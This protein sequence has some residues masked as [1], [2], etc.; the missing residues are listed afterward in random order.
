[1]LPPLP[2]EFRQ[3]SAKLGSDPQLV[4]G[5]GG[6]TSIKFDNVMW[7]KASGT[8][9]KNALNAD[10]FCPVDV[11][12]AR[13]CIDIDDDNATKEAVLPGGPDLKPSIETTFH[14]LLSDPV[15]LHVHSINVITHAISEEGMSALA[16]KL[17]DI[18]WLD[19]PYCRPGLPLTREIRRRKQAHHNVFILRN[20]GV[21]VSGQTT[22]EAYALLS[23]V[24]KRLTLPSLA[25]PSSAPQTDSAYAESQ[26]QWAPEFSA[27]ATNARLQHI[28]RQFT[29]YPDHCIFLGQALPCIKKGEPLPSQSPPVCLIEDTGVLINQNA[30]PSAIAMLGCL[31]DVLLKLP[32][33]W[34]PQ[35]LSTQQVGELL[36]W[37]AEKYRQALEAKGH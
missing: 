4:Q 36:N 25:I 22:A 34:T 31:Y 21:I 30:K 19:I 28:A 17:S 9:L 5:A 14:A 24:E 37:D 1:M 16:E 23:E 13:T 35:G 11:L 8:E 33:E 7:V 26:W 32:L 3:L 29:L 10:I 2:D 15:V 20:H 12:K 6:N 27:L 18:A